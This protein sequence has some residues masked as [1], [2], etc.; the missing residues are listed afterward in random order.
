MKAAR[1]HVRDRDLCDKGEL[2]A[3]TLRLSIL[4]L[5]DDEL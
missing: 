5:K 3:D 1:V 4:E 2:H